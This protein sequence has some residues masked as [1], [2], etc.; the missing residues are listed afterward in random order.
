MF[1]FRPTESANCS[2]HLSTS[3]AMSPNTTLN[4]F[5]ISSTFDAASTQSL[6]ND[7][8][9]ATEKTTAIFPKSLVA[10]FLIPFML[11]SA[12]CWDARSTSK[13]KATDI[14]LIVTYQDLL[15]SSS[16]LPFSISNCMEY[17]AYN[18]SIS[19]RV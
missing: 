18:F 11:F 3:S 6:A 16:A 10:I 15:S 9:L 1:L 2:A 12:C 14:S 19:S 13:P 17:S 7:V 5:S 8:S 4:L